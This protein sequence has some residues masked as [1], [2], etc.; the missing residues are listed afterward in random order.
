MTSL[1]ALK[2]KI[3][4]SQSGKVTLGGM[5]F[6]LSGDGKSITYTVQGQNSPALTRTIIQPVNGATVT[7]NIYGG[8]NEADVTGETHIQVGPEN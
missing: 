3:Q 5:V 8:G 6:G 7:G 2:T 1:N 4:A